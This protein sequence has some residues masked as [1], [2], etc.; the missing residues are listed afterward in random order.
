ML[1]ILLL[2]GSRLL[3]EKDDSGNM[4]TFLGDMC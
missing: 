3:K 2:M 4:S 1:L